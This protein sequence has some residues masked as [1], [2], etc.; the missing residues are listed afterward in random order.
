MSCGSSHYQS[1]PQR[2]AM[3]G[4][5]IPDR[6]ATSAHLALMRCHPHSLI[7]PLREKQSQLMQPS[8]VLLPREA[9]GYLR[10]GASRTTGTAHVLAVQWWVVVRDV[11]ARQSNYWYHFITHVCQSQGKLT[12]IRNC[13]KTPSDIDGVPQ[14]S[15]LLSRSFPSPITPRP[16]WSRR[17]IVAGRSSR[18]TRSAGATGANAAPVAA[19][20]GGQ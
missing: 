12:V 15:R 20:T 6:I 13:T 1:T 19:D 16:N 18:P 2:P 5:L 3:P 10:V 14:T 17:R 8:P 11:S 7:A 4:W 9:K